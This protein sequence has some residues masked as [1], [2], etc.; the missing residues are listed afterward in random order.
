[1][2]FLINTDR[3]PVLIIVSIEDL[4]TGVRFAVIILVTAV[5][6]SIARPTFYDSGRF[7]ITVCIQKLVDCGQIA[8]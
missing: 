3:I 1:M 5:V 8:V 7:V 6:E 2:D 4:G